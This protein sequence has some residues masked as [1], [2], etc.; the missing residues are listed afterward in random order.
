V[1]TPGLAPTKIV[2]RNTGN[3]FV[4]QNTSPSAGSNAFTV[5]RASYKV[6]ITQ[7]SHTVTFTVDLSG[8][9][10]TLSDI[11]CDYTLNFG[12]VSGV[13]VTIRNTSNAF[14]TSGIGS[15]SIS[16]T[17]IQSPYK[18]ITTGGIAS[19][20]TVGCTSSS[21]EETYVKIQL[22]DS[23]GIGLPGGVAQVNMSG[24]Q[25]LG[26]TNASG[27]VIL[28]L[29]G[30]PGTKPFRMKYAGATSATK[31]QNVTTNATVLFQTVKV[32]VRLLD[33]GFTGISGATTQYNAS[34]WKTIG[35]T[36]GLGET[37]I[38]LLPKSY[39]FRVKYAGATSNT[40]NQNVGANTTVTFQT[41]KVTVKLL[42][43]GGSGISGATTQY[44][45]SGW[46]TIGATNGSGE[47]MIELLPKSYPFRV[48]YAGATSL[49]KNQDVGTN[50]TVV[51][52]TV[53]VTVRLLDSGGS[54]ISGATTQYNASGWN[55][56]G[57]TNGS[58]ETM[59]ELLPKSYPFRVQYAGATSLTKNQDVGT[60]ATVIFQT[61]KVTVSV[62]DSCGNGLAGA[63]T[64]YSASGWNT[65]GTT[66]GS[67]ETMIELLPKSYPFRYKFGTS[68]SP[69]MNQ[70]VGSDPTVEF[71]DSS[72]DCTPPVITPL[73]AGTLGNNG[74]YTSNVTVSWTVADAQSG[75]ATSSGCGSTS[76]TSDTAGTTLT[77]SATNGD[78]Y[79][80]SVSV[81]IKIDKTDP[82]ISHSSPST[83]PW[84]NA[85][86][87]SN[88]SCSDALSGVVSA[89]V[90]ETTSGEGAAVSVTG[91]CTDNA[92]NTAS[93][94]QNYMIDKTDP[95]ISHSS[96]S[97]SS[98]YNA[99]VTSTWSCSDA[100]SGVVSATVSETTSGEGAA[101]SVTGI[102]TDNAGNTASDTQSYMIDKTDPTISH[103]SPSTSPWYNTD[104]TSTWSCLDGLSGVVSATVSETTSGEGASVSVTGTCTD[105]AGNTASDTQ[106]YMID[107][108]DPI[109]TGS[110]SPAA[111]SNGWNNTDVSVS[112][113]CTDSL[114]GVASGFPTGDTTLTGEGAGQSVTGDCEDEA[115]NSAST[116]V[117]GIN[118][119]KTDPIITGSQSPLANSNGWNN[120]DVDISF[121]C[122]DS[123]SGV[124]TGFPTGDTTLTG[125]GAGQ[126]VTGN[127]EDKA[128]NSS[129]ITVSG[130]NIDKTD[131]SISGSRSPLAN[132]NGWNNTDVSVSFSCTDALS[133]VETGNPTGDATLAGEGAGQSATG[134]CVDK[135]GNSAS[136]TVSDINIDK[137]D[138]SITGSRAPAANSNGWNNTDVDISFSCTDSLSG[139]ESGFPTGDTT[140][141]G[142]GAGQSVTGDCEDKAGNSS[143]ITVSDINIDKTAP[144]I[145]VSSLIDG[146][147]FILSELVI[148]NWAADDN[149]S[150]FSAFS[151]V[152][153]GGQVPTDAVGTHIITIE[154]VDIAGNTHS[155]TVTYQVVYEILETGKLRV[156]GV[157][158]GSF[159]DEEPAAGG[160][161]SLGAL[162]IEEDFG[163]YELGQLVVLRFQL[164]DFDGA[165]VTTATPT[166]SIIRVETDE[167]GDETRS[168][169]PDIF[170]FE[171][172][173][174]SED[175]DTDVV[176]GE[177][178]LE[179]DTTDFEAGE[180]ELVIQLDD[181]TSQTVKVQLEN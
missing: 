44:N 80:N 152:A 76:L 64:Q 36:D 164:F 139:V 15:S 73:I 154:V 57:T 124:E 130:I 175:E 174:D 95:T 66:N 70:N 86:V 1:L 54:G 158:V 145:T 55:T 48:Q 123:L 110:P 156:D 10:E 168:V 128:G 122:T 103:S 89:T 9:D 7:G 126:S 31:N 8:G 96:P 28:F 71:T 135:A 37:M 85:D 24:W 6:L 49:T 162:G 147:V 47:T 4:T 179:L 108:T 78:G 171:F 118:I 161:A 82:T 112:F 18:I 134:N 87:T 29:S 169:L 148:F 33:S 141:T 142:E 170:D 153:N 167:S 129:S 11:V 165:S 62:K 19:N 91:T 114:S 46:N 81:M 172:L 132:S 140:L 74:W 113:S 157:E 178:V 97:T 116:T 101:V 83:S 121:G 69:T 88:W 180:Y 176:G 3:A 30:S 17:L 5:L 77:C 93:D 137:T 159:L 120:T 20:R 23:G 102:C 163:I 181:G 68:T 41:V 131:P 94:I 79:S 117:S 56:I 14:V 151:P 50:T 84:Y 106:S 115:G 40:L 39:P 21:V 100:L 12:G 155:V 25:T 45:A 60:N 61:V 90:S 42:D 150:V 67:G 92:G 125:E 53:K 22:L 136:A 111:N 146:G 2:I 107:K 98:W 32:T 127:C 75:V 51:F 133:G 27:E 34:G 109:I 104:V 65:I 166:L 138:P 63:T 16:F 119:D 105:N 173:L 72:L 58:G 38:E 143:S 43:S 26:T 149:V 35:T 177:Y 144:T 52:Q 13:S 160:G 59:I 99:D